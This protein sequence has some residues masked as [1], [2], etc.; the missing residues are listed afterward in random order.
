MRVVALDEAEDRK[1][2]LALSPEPSLVDEFPLQ[3]G[4][5]TVSQRVNERLDHLRCDVGEQAHDAERY[6]IAGEL[7]LNRLPGSPSGPRR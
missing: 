6:D 5:E 3:R 4:E 2:C 7:A 1:A